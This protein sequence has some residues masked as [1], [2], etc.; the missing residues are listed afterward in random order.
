MQINNSNHGSGSTV[1]RHK[2]FQRLRE[3]R[4]GSSETEAWKIDICQTHRDMAS[5]VE[6]IAY[7]KAQGCE[8]MM[9]H[10]K[11]FNMARTTKWESRR[12]EVTNEVGCV[13]SSQPFKSFLYPVKFRFYSVNTMKILLIIK[14]S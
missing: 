6:Q 8:K 14:N 4:G 11:K 12:V 7:T 13:S 1:H 3:G 5:H 9:G 10:V 2:C